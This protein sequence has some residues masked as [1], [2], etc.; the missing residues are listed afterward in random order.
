[1][2]RAAQEEEAAWRASFKPHAIILTE[3]ERPE[4]IFLAALIGVERLLR[5]DFDLE[6]DRESYAQK[7][8]QGMQRHLAKWKG[9]VPA[10]GQPIGFVVNYSPDYAIRFDLDG[11]P[12]EFFRK[13]YRVGQAH[14]LVKGRPISQGIFPHVVSS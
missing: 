8:L 13:A 6:G 7:A 10:F 9:A 4:P 12:R 1:M 5:V 11:M 14:L 2:H 3:R